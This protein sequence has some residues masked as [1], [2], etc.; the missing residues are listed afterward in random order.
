[1]NDLEMIQAFA[2]LEGVEVG[3]ASGEACAMAMDGNK[4]F[5]YAYYNPITDLAFNCAMRDKYEVEI[6]YSNMTALIRDENAGEYDIGTLADVEILSKGVNRA[7]IECILK[8]EG[9]YNDSTTF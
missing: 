7:V 8:S 6:C 5:P 1:M 4:R 2:K 3:V 9:L